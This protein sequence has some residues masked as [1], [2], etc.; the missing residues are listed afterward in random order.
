M[1]SEIG[2]GRSGKSRRSGRGGSAPRRAL[3]PL[4]LLP[5][6]PL[7]LLVF[8]A[9]GPSGDAKSQERAVPDSGYVAQL[10]GDHTLTV[11]R[12]F[13]VGVFAKDL[14][15]VRFMAVGPDGA[16]YASLRRPGKVVRLTDADGDGR[17]EAPTVVI[18]GLRGPHG[19][20][21]RGDTLYIAEEHRVIR[22]VPPDRRVEVVVGGLPTGGNHFTRTILFRDHYL[23]VSIG[24]SCNLCRESD[25]RRAAVVRY[26]LDGSGETL[27][28]TG[29]RNSVGLALEPVTGAIWGTN[30]DRDRLGDDRPPDRVNIIEQGGWYGWPDCYLPNTPNPEYAESAAKCANAIGP[31]VTL[32]AHAAPLGLAFYTGTQFPA[33]YRGD[34]FVALHGS[35]DRSVPIGYEVVRVPVR[36]GKPAGPWSDFVSGWQV[37]RSWWGRPVDP[38]VAPDGSLLISDDAGGKIFRV[39]YE[40]GN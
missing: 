40:G 14:E 31:A 36:N 22:L 10:V 39:W 6:L 4:P 16:I 32:P 24:S 30:N 33:G 2:S 37:G 13:H 18:E 12:G 35:W 17:G 26:N 3:P 28:A 20:A 7:L 27:F 9:C 1:Q 15:N 29:L 5:R 23:Y 34:L 21:F 8:P 19:L 25:P 11:P 38:I